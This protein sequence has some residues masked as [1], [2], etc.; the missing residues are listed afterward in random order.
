MQQ[1]ASEEAPKTAPE[2]APAAAWSR[3]GKLKLYP[4]AGTGVDPLSNVVDTSLGG[5]PVSTQPVADTF[6]DGLP[7]ADLP[8]IGTLLG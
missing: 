5:I 1:Q 2:S 3:L 8:V 7:V 6:A 4:L